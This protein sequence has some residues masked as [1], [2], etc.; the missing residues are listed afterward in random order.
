VEFY[1]HKREELRDKRQNID[2][3]LGIIDKKEK[4]SKSTRKKGRQKGLEGMGP[5]PKILGNKK[6]GR[7]H[8]YK[9]REIR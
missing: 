1:K 7:R 4:R 9:S 6:V 5:N 2:Q 8:P 3:I